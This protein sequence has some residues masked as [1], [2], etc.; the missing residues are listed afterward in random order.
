MGT[1]T[2]TDIEINVG[3]DYRGKI[4]RI[5]GNSYQNEYE[6][7]QIIDVR[8]PSTVSR[9]NF[10]F[11]N[12]TLTIESSEEV[13]GGY[14]SVNYVITDIIKKHP[15]EVLKFVCESVNLSAFV[16]TATLVVQFA[17]TESGTTTYKQMAWRASAT[18]MTYSTYTIPNDVSNI[19][20]FRCLIYTNNTATSTTS[21]TII[22][23]PMLQFGTEEK[24]YEPYV[25]T[26]PAP[27]PEFPQEVVSIGSNVNLFDKNNFT[28]RNAYFLNQTV[29]NVGNRRMLAM[30]CKPNTTYTIQKRNDGT[31]NI[32]QVGTTKEYP[33]A[34]VAIYDIISISTA[35]SITITSNSEAQYFICTYYYTNETKL[36]EQEVLDSIKIEEGDKATSY[37]KYNYGG[38]DYKIQNKNLFDKDNANI[39]NGY[40]D[41]S[42]KIVGNSQ[43][44]LVYISCKPNTTYTISKML[45][46]R[47]AVAYTTDIPA[48]NVECRGRIVNHTATEITI[49]TDNTANYLVAF[50]YHTSYD[51][52]ITLQQVLDSIQI[53][54][55]PIATTYVEHQEK[56]I[57]IPLPAGTEL[58]KVGDYKDNI[59][60]SNNK[61]YK[62]KVINKVVFNGEETWNISGTGT[63]VYFYT[64]T[65]SPIGVTSTP[66]L[67]NFYKNVQVYTSN[68][69][70][71]IYITTTTSSAI[72]VRYGAEMST[73]DFQAYLLGK[74]TAGTPLKVYYPL[75]TPV[76]E[77]IT[78][79]ET[80]EAL[81][82]S[83]KIILYEGKNTISNLNSPQSTFQLDYDKIVSDYDFY[84]SADGYFIS[85]KENIKNKINPYESNIPS[86]A[87][88]TQASARVAGTDG[89]I[90][91][92]TTYEPISFNIVCYTED[93]LTPEEKIEEEEKV[94]K[95]LNNIKNNTGKLAFEEQEKFYE[96]RYSGA[97]TTTR[98]PKHLKF[99][100]PLKSSKS[101]S[102]YFVESY[103]EGNATFESNTVKETGGIFTIKGPATAP[104]IYFND[105]EM[106]YTANLTAGQKL[107]IDSNNSTA[108]LIAANGTKSNA[109]R[110]YNHQFPKIENG[111]N[112]LS[113][114][115]GVDVSQVSLKWYDLK[116]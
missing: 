83:Q 82:K 60:K 41:A 36:T 87:E 8:N 39:Y 59:Y 76:E 18:S 102:K 21:K 74:Y 38:I 51:T 62:H 55:S 10:S 47:F 108:T 31:N 45:S 23:K 58:C 54:E 109:M 80:I 29:T 88:A 100:I 103:V 105:Y 53:E 89:D 94:N 66:V 16:S 4:N 96:V 61:W 49:T 99:A 114:Y 78:D 25:G 63:D 48:G 73:T 92:Q 111:T 6:G 52:E 110:Y 37:T 115:S 46:A 33:D 28:K 113:I 69:N 44:R 112:E 85:T 24:N 12:D 71:G 67:S 77:E 72:R 97:L 40:P 101:F 70:Q 19:T 75:A 86:M 34:G 2:G 107:I 27:S 56:N 3:K 43:S 17:I 50:V 1:I 14:N 20:N 15:G 57:T 91:L 116:F 64:K 79:E 30:P 42:E 68:T 90:P 35:S 5:D 95:F 98:Y 93:N 11:V 106:Y 65:I 13:S 104:K 81:E 32:F 7:N 26:L 22:T 84:I 9:V